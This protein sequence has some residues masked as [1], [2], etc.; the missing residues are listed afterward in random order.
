MARIRS[1][2][3][4]FWVSEQIGNCSRNARLLFIG[5]WSFCDDRGVHPA[6]PRTLKAEVFPQDEDIA[7][8]D[9]AGWLQELLTV[10]LIAT[11]E[12]DGAAYWHV[13]GWAKHQRIDKPSNKHPAP[14]VSNSTSIPRILVESSPSAKRQE[15]D[16]SGS[17]TRSFA[18]GVEGKGE[19]GKGEEDSKP[20]A[21][22]SA[23]PTRKAPTIACP[24][25]AI[26]AIYNEVLADMLPRAKL[27]DG[28]RK[29]AMAKRWA[30]VLNSTKSDGT[31]RATTEEEALDWVRGFFEQ[32]KGNDFLMGKTH[33]SAEHANW[34]CGLDHLMTDRCLK[35]VIEMTE[36][37]A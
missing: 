16:P 36:E 19:E 20:S 35:Q 27:M 21:S 29:K 7:S 23:K 30:W 37:A 10:G 5:L 15:S 4:E 28:D 13:T 25:E 6:K 22:S 9:V 33:R 12:V 8:T 31:R 11:F 32:A 24:F 1:I 17:A 2:K 34:R 18:P 3:P 14:P 26:Q